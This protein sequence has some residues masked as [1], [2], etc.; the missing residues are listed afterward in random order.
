MK[1]PIKICGMKY[2]TVEVATLQPAYL[3]FI[4]YDKSPRYF[5]NAIPTLPAGVKKVGVFVNASE[6][7]ILNTIA[8]HQLDII[9]LHGEETPAYCKSLQKKTSNLNIWKVFS[10]KD[11]FNFETL[12]PYEPYVD[13]FLFDTKGKNKGGNGFTFDWSVL[14][15]YPSKK[16]FVL[17]GGIGLDSLSEV[18]EIVTSGLPILA[19]DVNSKFES[20]PGRKKVSQ[21][22][23]FM[24]QL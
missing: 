18:Q 16:P 17:S 9:Q 12:P 20:E 19:I 13:A 2:N 1:P 6:E 15:N 7:T 8:T 3:G 14:K 21:L 11:A 10:I 4:F 24:D 22:E 23:K 5:N